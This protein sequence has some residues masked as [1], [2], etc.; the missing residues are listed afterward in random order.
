MNNLSLL[1]SSLVLSVPLALGCVV[2]SAEG[3]AGGGF[4]DAGSAVRCTPDNAVSTV[5]I[6]KC[7]GG[8]CHDA[9]EP[10]AG[11]DLASAG[12]PDRLM[13]VASGAC[14]DKVLV[15]AGDATSSY[16]VEKLGPAPSCGDPMPKGGTPL[17]AEEVGCIEGW[18]AGLEP[19]GNDGSGGSGGTG[20]TGGGGGGGW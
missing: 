2:D 9:S 11:L 18:V 7:T 8:A 3:P 16:L 20:G 12:L 6:P 4:A 10:A 15:V 14:T 17:S 5:I 1:I 13:N 19:G